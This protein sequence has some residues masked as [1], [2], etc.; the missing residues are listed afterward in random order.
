MLTGWASLLVHGLNGFFTGDHFLCQSAEGSLYEGG[1]SPRPSGA[2]ATWIPV[3]ELA[4]YFLLPQ[5]FWRSSPRTVRPSNTFEPRLRVHLGLYLAV[6]LTICQRL[7]RSYISFPRIF[8]QGDLA[9]GQLLYRFFVCAHGR[10]V[11]VA[12]QGVGTCDWSAAS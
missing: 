9:H 12:I 7:R 2:W 1:E 11:S 3:Q 5:I 4:G 8:R 10:A 6:T